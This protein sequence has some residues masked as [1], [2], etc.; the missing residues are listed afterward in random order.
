MT[1]KTYSY[2]C[3]EGPRSERGSGGRAISTGFRLPSPK[4]K[5][6]NSQVMQKQYF[7]EVF[8]LALRS[9]GYFLT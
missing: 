7:C 6:E 8:K 3:D 2:N 9:F 5:F 4:G 1:A